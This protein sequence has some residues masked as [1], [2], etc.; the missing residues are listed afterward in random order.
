M[1]G[2][3]YVWDNVVKLAA[4]SFLLWVL[5]L[6]AM[7]GYRRRA[8]GTMSAVLWVVFVV[9]VC[10]AVVL[11]VFYN[12]WFGSI[13]FADWKYRGFTSSPQS[14]TFTSRCSYWLQQNPD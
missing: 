14:W 11:D 13:L 12:L 4:S 9:V 2:I 7:A 5:Y 3:E 1:F 10:L 6:L 8:A